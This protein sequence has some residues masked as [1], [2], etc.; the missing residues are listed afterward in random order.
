MGNLCEETLF[1]IG[2][3]LEVIAHKSKNLMKSQ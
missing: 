2:N 3:F 1:L